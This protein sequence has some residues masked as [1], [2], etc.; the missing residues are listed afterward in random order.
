MH[1]WPTTLPDCQV[2]FVHEMWSLQSFAQ[3]RHSFLIWQF[4]F[5]RTTLCTPRGNM[6]KGSVV[7]REFQFW[8]SAPPPLSLTFQILS[9]KPFL[10]PHKKILGDI[11]QK[12]WILA[13][14]LS[15]LI[16]IKNN[17][18]CCLIWQSTDFLFS[19]VERAEH[20]MWRHS[21]RIGGRK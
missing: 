10:C 20:C 5:V 7:Q 6:E 18:S 11:D 3:M 8:I 19:L 1:L 9:N 2:L 17:F 13:Y 15:K 16:S 4:H 21:W 14:S 12:E